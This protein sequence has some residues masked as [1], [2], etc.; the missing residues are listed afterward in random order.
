MLTAGHPRTE[1]DDVYYQRGVLVIRGADGV[2]GSAS[3]V[4]HVSTAS[5]AAD[6]WT[7][8][9]STLRDLAADP[10]LASY[11]LLTNPAPRAIS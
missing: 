8:P 10:S 5:Q 3:E 1:N 2:I 6:A 7:V 9:V 4:V 11:D